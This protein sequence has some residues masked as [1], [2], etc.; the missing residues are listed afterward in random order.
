MER[1][2][3]WDVDGTLV[4]CGEVGAA[5]FDLAIEHV[6]GRRPPRRIRMSGK[7][8]PQIVGEYLAMLA[9]EH[10]DGPA[11]P[12]DRLVAPDI[13]A[14]GDRPAT[15]VE[16]GRRLP[17]TGP[18]WVP[19]ARTA[20]VLARLEVELAAAAAELRHGRALPGVPA[21]L[22]ALHHDPDTVQTVLTGNVR[23]NAALKLG[24]FGLLPWLDLSIGA[25]GSDHVERGRLV[26][27]ALE[28]VADR[29]GHHPPPDR[30][31]VV[32]DA[33]N[34]LA[35]ARAAGVNCL[36][37]ATGRTAAAELAD[38]G[39]DAMLDD[40]SDTAAVLDVLRSAPA[41]HP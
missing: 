33:P 10:V 36:L 6:T 4:S 32:G 25:F 26:P 9:A 21:L 5:V 37:V 1:L 35:A 16:A 15:A 24:A 11:G 34:D 20:A 12:T 30:V 3:L 2:V 38:L 8:D 23:A 14:A 13:S 27:M 28:R 19:D 7:T 40:L 41:R 31:W 39:P 22:S 18:T 17:A 29:F